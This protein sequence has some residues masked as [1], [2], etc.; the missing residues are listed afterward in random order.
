MANASGIVCAI[1][2]PRNHAALLDVVENVHA[3][4][5]CDIDLLHGRQN[6]TLAK[7][8]QAALPPAAVRLH[9]LPVD[10][11]TTETY[12]DLLTSTAFWN[13]IRVMNPQSSHALIFQTD[14]GVCAPHT[15]SH[16]SSL[17]AAQR[18]EYC[19]AP[20]PPPN[21][22]G[23]GGFSLR[24]IDATRTL[25][26]TRAA[27]KGSEMAEDIFFSFHL[28]TCPRDTALRF[29]AESSFRGGSDPPLGFHA[30]WKHESADALAVCPQATRNHLLNAFH[31]AQS[32][33]VDELGRALNNCG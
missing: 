15:H 19:G 22:V 1:V 18:F 13:R 26:Q 11:L 3:Q 24:H 29:A 31:D 33:A 7:Q 8:V 17:L 10:D 4:I 12:S 21:G 32:T 20:W 14:S 27:P 2:E 9:R 28:R 23:N 25:L 16:D 6:E 30:W 5:G